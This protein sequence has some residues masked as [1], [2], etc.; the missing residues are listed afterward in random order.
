M[1]FWVLGWR[2]WRGC[3][4]IRRKFRDGM[5]LIWCCCVWWGIGLTCLLLALILIV[6]LNASK[7]YKISSTSNKATPQHHNKP[8]TKL[9]TKTT[10]TNNNH[11]CNKN[12]PNPNTHQSSSTHKPTTSNSNTITV[13]YSSCFIKNYPMITTFTRICNVCL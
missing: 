2:Y 9:K 1:G 11:K 12:N 7:C 6:K 10:T 13:K 3:L 8:K 5:G 4:C